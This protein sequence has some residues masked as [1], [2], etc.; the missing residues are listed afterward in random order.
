MSD[1]KPSPE[2]LLAAALETSG[3]AERR[4]YLD[5]ACGG[6]AA[7]R[8][9]VESLLDAKS[10]RRQEPLVAFSGMIRSPILGMS[11]NRTGRQL[12]NAPDSV[13]ASIRAFQREVRSDEIGT[14]VVPCRGVVRRLVVRQ[15]PLGLC[16][17][18]LTQFIDARILRGSHARTSKVGDNYSDEQTNDRNPKD[19]DFC[20]W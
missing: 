18:N 13:Y 6:D 12:I 17:A 10:R 16:S 20:L 7:L 15:S 14:K 2:T 9:E 5:R 3:A 11:G 8:Q 19:R 1:L 4:A